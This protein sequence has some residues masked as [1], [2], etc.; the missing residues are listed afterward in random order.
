MTAFPDTSFLFA[1]YRSQ[2]NSAAAR[3]HYEAM[4]EPV[5]VSGLLLYEFRQSMRFQVWLHAQN[6]TRG[7]TAKGA[8][9]AIAD[10]ES[11]LASGALQILPVD[12]A[13]VLRVAERLSAACT[14]TG[15]HRETCLYHDEN[16]DRSRHSQSL[17]PRQR[18][19]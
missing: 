11:N 4:K 14:K 13:H 9:Q 18:V 12:A 5:A 1:L 8:D 2:D 3:R 15:G 19:D 16:C 7:I 6:P 10:L 17:C